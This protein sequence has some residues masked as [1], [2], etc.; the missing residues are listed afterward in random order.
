MLILQFLSDIKNDQVHINGQS[1]KTA[2]PLTTNRHICNC[3]L[4]FFYTQTFRW[5]SKN[6][7]QNKF[8]W[9]MD[10]VW[11]VTCNAA[12][13]SC[14]PRPS[15]TRSLVAITSKTSQHMSWRLF[16]HL[17]SPQLTSFHLNWVGLHCGWSHP[18]RTGSLSSTWTSLQWLQPISSDEMRSV[19][20]KRWM[21]KQKHRPKINSAGMWIGHEKWPAMQL[22]AAARLDRLELALW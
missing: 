9:Y 7:G 14:R 8:S 1:V 4:P 12:Q 15:G 18:W 17:T 16:T 11:K 19:K 21:N 3:R 13:C 22:N 2:E 10:R 20:M 6:V 5:I